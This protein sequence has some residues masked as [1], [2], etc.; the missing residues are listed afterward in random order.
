MTKV[1]NF[2]VAALIILNVCLQACTK[3]PE[4]EAVTTAGTF[5]PGVDY[6]LENSTVTASATTLKSGESVNIEV[7][8]NDPNSKPFTGTLSVTFGLSGGSSTGQFSTATKGANGS[9]TATFTGGEAGTVTYLNTYLDGHL[10]KTTRPVIQVNHADLAVNSVSPT[11]SF[12]FGGK[13]LTVNG[14]GFITGITVSI[15][16]E[17]CSSVTLI[18]STQLTCVNPRV[19][20]PG[21]KDIILT[22]TNTIS[23][24]LTNGFEYKSDMFESIQLYS[25][26]LTNYGPGDGVGTSVRLNLPTKIVNHNND[27]FYIADTLNHVIRKYHRP[28]NTMSVAFGSI[29]FSGT[30]DAN[31][32]SAK[33]NEPIGL[34]IIGSIMYVSDSRSCLIRRID[35]T[36][37]D[38]TTI[39]GVMNTCD[40]VDNTVGTSSNFA[41]PAAM[42][43]DGSNLYVIVGSMG[44]SIG[45]R[46][47]A[48]SGSYPVT[49]FGSL[50]R[51][52]ADI[53][54]D[55]GYLYMSDINSDI[56]KYNL[57]DNTEA[58]VAGRSASDE[59]ADGIGTNAWFS[60]P[61]GMIKDGN[62]LYISDPGNCA[63]RK[64][65]LATNE[66]STVAGSRLA[67][68]GI[69]GNTDDIGLGAKLAQVTGVAQYNFGGTNELYFISWSY[70]N[71]RKVNLTT[72]Q[73]TTLT[74][75][76]GD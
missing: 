42:T 20:S 24:T 14:A 52:I 34:V 28:T 70:N 2:K 25:G 33:F 69:C 11:S 38:V 7:K 75:P 48:L 47:V 10:L 45:F 46:K 40:N 53:L 37:K 64:L 19:S 60:R 32:T 1:I 49:S 31:G 26:R 41:Y 65:D 66:V 61:G 5:E 74:G 76:M 3:P 4:K 51:G 55:A 63:I 43:T 8:I 73:V 59:I 17:P 29:G 68:I 57:A 21:A 13:T 6:S 54:Y 30:V 16:G 23:A 12:L 15:G 56:V 72:G 50:N 18:S 22:N 27:D 35:L 39:A 44:S 58:I 67:S 71:L 9:Y 36:T 62:T